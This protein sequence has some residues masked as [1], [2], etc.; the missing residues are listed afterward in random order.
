MKLELFSSICIIYLFTVKCLVFEE[1]RINA[2]K[3]V[4]DSKEMYIKQTNV[5]VR[6]KR[7]SK[8]STIATA[9]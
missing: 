7:V 2:K 1:H 4:R 6:N 9:M 8:E 5:R 3:Y